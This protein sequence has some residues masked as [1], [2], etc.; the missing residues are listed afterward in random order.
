M[1]TSDR[2]LRLPQPVRTFMTVFA[3]VSSLAFWG[4]AWAVAQSGLHQDA[5]R[6]FWD[7]LSQLCGQA[8]AGGMAVYDPAEDADWVDQPMTIHVR[9]CSDDQIQIPL[10]VG[11]DRSR[12][13][14]VTKLANGLEL[15][16]V[17][18]HADGSLDTVSWYGGQT[19]DKGTASRQ[20]FAADAYSQSLFFAEGLDVSVAN[21][22][23]LTVE[24]GQLAYGL[25]RPNRHFR[26]EFDLT[27]PV[28]APPP[29]WGHAE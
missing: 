26:A 8:F 16:H 1:L 27:K 10:V 15:K 2:W 25:T 4:P 28:E 23:Y 6:D 24:A 29:P 3:M 20:A 17:H 14:V 22:W 5:Q 19:T 12:T 21:I 7:E 11:D 18:R 13:W 9:E